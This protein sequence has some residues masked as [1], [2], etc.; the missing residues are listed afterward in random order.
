MFHVEVVALSIT[1]K[2]NY[3]S[4]LIIVMRDS[5]H[6]YI[7]YSYFEIT[8]LN[9]IHSVQLIKLENISRVLRAGRIRKEKKELI[10]WNYVNLYSLPNIRMRM[11]SLG[12]V[13]HMCELYKYIQQ[14][15]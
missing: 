4:I 9:D 5:K 8:I 14:M 1:K 15:V 12:H 2:Y 6:N 11:R 3:L 10:I 13:L 7:H